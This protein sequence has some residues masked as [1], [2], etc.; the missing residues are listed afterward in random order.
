MAVTMATPNSQALPRPDRIFDQHW[1]SDF[2]V[3]QTYNRHIILII[4]INN[5]IINDTVSYCHNHSRSHHQ[6]C[7]SAYGIWHMTYGAVVVFEQDLNIGY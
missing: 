7:R 3:T 1:I 5:L 4:N 6:I 2:S